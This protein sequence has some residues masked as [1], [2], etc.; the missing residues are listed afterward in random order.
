MNTKHITPTELAYTAL[1]RN[2]PVIFENGIE[3]FAI[4]KLGSDRLLDAKT[5]QIC[6]LTTATFPKRLFYKI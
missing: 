1:V 5:I 4:N 2:I 3:I 6:Y